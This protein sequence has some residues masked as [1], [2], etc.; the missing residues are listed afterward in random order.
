MTSSGTD[1]MAVSEI[2]HRRVGARGPT[3][4][5]HLV[6]KSPNFQIITKTLRYS[7]MLFAH[8]CI[9]VHPCKASAYTG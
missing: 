6:S 8:E 1:R 9:M 3:P 7:P 2:C 4:F 5:M